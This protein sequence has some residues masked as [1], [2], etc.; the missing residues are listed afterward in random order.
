MANDEIG[1]ATTGETNGEA[2]VVV[3]ASDAGLVDLE[4][5]NVVGV[6]RVVV[7]TFALFRLQLYEHFGVLYSQYEPLRH[8]SIRVPSDLYYSPSILQVAVPQGRVVVFLETLVVEAWECG[9]N[10]VTRVN[11]IIDVD[12]N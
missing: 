12:V 3:R 2:S 8:T 1:G 10:L 6:S 4:M 11:R 9:D 7:V 5:M